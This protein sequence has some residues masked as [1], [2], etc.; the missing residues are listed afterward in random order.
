M[1]LQDYVYEPDDT[2]DI[3]GG[4]GEGGW[5]QTIRASAGSGKTYQ[6]STR[7]LSLIRRDAEPSEVLATTFTR[8][9]AGEV[10]GRVITRLADAVVDP[11]KRKD[12]AESLDDP[13]LTQADCRAMLRSL[14]DS[15]HRLSIST[16]DGFFNRM[17]QSFRYELDLPA[18]P[19][20]IDAMHPV[21]VRLRRDAIEAMLADDDLPTLVT[22]LRQLHHD[23]AARS[24]TEAIDSAVTGLYEVYREALDRAVWSRLEPLGRM[25]EDQFGHTV[26]ALESAAAGLPK[27]KHWLNAYEENRN[28]IHARDWKRFIGKGLA[29]KIVEGGETFQRQPITSDWFDIFEPLI[30]HASGELIYR[31][32]QQTLATYDLLQRFDEHYAPLRKRQGVLLFS[33]ITHKL[34]HELPKS[35]ELMQDVY[36]RLDGRVTHLLLDEF[37]DTSLSQWDVLR[38]FAQEIAATADGSRTLFCV[39]DT[40][41]AIYGWRGG[42]AELFD[43]FEDTLG[44][45]ESCRLTMSR[46]YRS[47]A[48]VLDA[49]N[50]VFTG[51]ASNDALTEV[52][53]A[54]ERWQNGFELHEAVRDLPGHVTL[55]TSTAGYNPDTNDEDTDDTDDA[56]PASAGAHEAYVARRVKALYEREGGAGS[57]GVL[58]SRNR[59]A[60]RLIYELGKLGL[61]VSGEG[62]SRLTDSPVV[63]AVLSALVMA[64]HPGDTASS[65]HVL[66]SPLGAV[67]GLTSNHEA[68]VRRASL[69][70]RRSLLTK[71]YAK[72]ISVWA[73]A[74]ARS[75]DAR[76]VRRLTQLIELAD[77][78]EPN[79]PLRPSWF[80]DLVESAS[81][82]EPSQ[83]PIRVMTIHGSKGLEFDTVVLAELDRKL[84]DRSVMLI[85]RDDP[86]G[87]ITG[88]YRNADKAVRELDEN[89]K[90]TAESQRQNRIIEDLCSL[91]VAMTRARQALHMIVTPME[92]TKTGKLKSKGL[93]FASI[94]RDALNEAEETLDGEQVLYEAG[95]AQWSSDAKPPVAVEP[96][97]PAAEPLRGLDKPTDGAWRSWPTIAPSSQ[98]GTDAG[99]GSPHRSA[100]DLLDVT[101]KDNTAMRYGTLVHEWMRLVGFIDEDTLPDDAA[102][103][104]VAQRVMPGADTSW[105]VSRMDWLRQL[106]AGPVAQEAL[107]RNGA[108]ELWR[109]R[110]FAVSDHGQ[111]L[112]GF[113]DRVTIYRDKQGKISQARLIDFK[114]DRLGDSG[115]HAIA[116]HYRPQMR[117]YQ[118]ALMKMLNL[119]P[120]AVTISLWLVG[121]DRLVEL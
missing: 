65:F 22:L 99:G 50:R 53:E 37:Q 4:R 29:K 2:G 109:E 60:S 98:A 32:A 72:T 68:D 16:I 104:A 93:C 84:T 30:G 18:E 106:W 102:L 58:V 26:A 40:K 25:D 73:S 64:D 79:D 61:P 20:L 63:M 74:V 48:V 15:L 36:F 45:D 11:G 17:A 59:S 5:H 82:A 67:I 10:L 105:I 35:D 39:G 34:S 12:L 8:K 81:V 69:R 77:R 55:E 111:L 56:L 57:I 115:E 89:L 86:T 108:Q 6:L 23:A 44:L 76:S 33:D 119:D 51:I 31:V 19:K 42:V 117:V 113:F 47:S 54:A 103:S 75:C 27:N 13:G 49:V 14:T 97:M 80:V 85:E 107:A 52:A 46:S 87:P 101:P 24:V 21:A 66:N 110:G 41:Q 95:D 78:S 91:Y 96:K 28:A 9:A 3:S 112:Q 70:V 38:P 114:T 62:G 71:G 92:L 94:L 121:D 88:A 1:N 43:T 118:R 7:Y 120:S 116:D 100:A 90:H 83:A